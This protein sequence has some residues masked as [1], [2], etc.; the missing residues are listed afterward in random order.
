LSAFKESFV[1]FAL[2]AEKVKI[3]ITT[4]LGQRISL[5]RI[6]HPDIKLLGH[7]PGGRRIEKQLH[8]RFSKDCLGGEWFRFTPE[9]QRTIERLLSIMTPF[10]PSAEWVRLPKE[11]KLCG[12]SHLELLEIIAKGN[13]KSVCLKP[14]SQLIYVPTLVAYLQDKT[15]RK[16]VVSNQLATF[17]PV[18]SK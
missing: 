10:P 6:A 12:I 17:F 13:I 4:N 14:K 18:K 8:S 11:E 9:L 3:G 2:S 7:I 16:P 15:I 5:L 1:Y